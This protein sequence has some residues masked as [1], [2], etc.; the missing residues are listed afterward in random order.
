MQISVKVYVATSLPKHVE[1]IWI[2]EVFDNSVFKEDF[3]ASDILT[4]V[5]EYLVKEKGYIEHPLWVR[6]IFQQHW[7]DHMQATR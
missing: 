5:G 7:L 6:L 1:G 4:K 3:K 2:E